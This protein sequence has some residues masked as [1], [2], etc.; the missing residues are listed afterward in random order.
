MNAN[1]DSHRWLDDPK[2]CRH[3]RHFILGV[4]WY[5]VTL[6]TVITLINARF[7]ESILRY[8]LILIPVPGA[9]WTIYSSIQLVRN[10]DELAQKIHT[11]AAMISALVTAALTFTYGFL[12]LMGFPKMMTFL[13]FPTMIALWGIF[14]P[15]VRRRYE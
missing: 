11:E 3:T 2:N 5:S 13:F 6:M 15:F 8:F 12:E 4:V 9:L 1:S 10:M 14:T 7:E